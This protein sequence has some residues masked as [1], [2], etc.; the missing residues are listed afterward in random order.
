M[1]KCPDCKGTGRRTHPGDGGGFGGE[2]CSL[3]E[4][5]G[6]VADAHIHTD[7][8]LIFVA[9]KPVRVCGRTGYEQ[10]PRIV[11]ADEQP[12]PHFVAV[13]SA[14]MLGDLCVGKMRSK[15]MAKRTAN[16]LNKHVPNREGV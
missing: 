5:S 7:K 4:G 9:G 13:K 2:S 6:M 1:R 15:T 10:Q 3:C 16:A 11:P 12:R 14:V 8:C